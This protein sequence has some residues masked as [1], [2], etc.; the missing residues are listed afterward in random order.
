MEKKLT[1]RDALKA[2][3]GA[4]AF[5]FALPQL[6]WLSSQDKAVTPPPSR[7]ELPS[8]HASSDSWGNDPLVII[9]KGDEL[10]GFRGQQEFT[11][12]DEE[13]IKRL[14]GTFERIQEDESL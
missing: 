11:V 12:R 1:R 6:P 14:Q 9:V 4:S 5:F 3:A 10:V 7:N 13:L 8:H 2:S